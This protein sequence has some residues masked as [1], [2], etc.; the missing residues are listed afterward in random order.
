MKKSEKLIGDPKNDEQVVNEF[1]DITEKVD[2]VCMSR[3]GRFGYTL[4]KTIID[5]T[6]YSRNRPRAIKIRI[7][8]KLKNLAHIKI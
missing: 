8:T 7:G 5:A 1:N 4:D 2:T 3:Q 6:L